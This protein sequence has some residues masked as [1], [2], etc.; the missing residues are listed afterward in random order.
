MTC[1]HAT[2]TQI[3]YSELSGA[4]KRK[5]KGSCISDSAVGCESPWPEH[6]STQKYLDSW[7]SKFRKLCQNKRR[8]RQT[9]DEQYEALAIHRGGKMTWELS[10]KSGLHMEAFQLRNS[11]I[12]N[13]TISTIEG[14]QT[15][16]HVK[17]GKVGVPRG[18]D[19]LR[20]IDYCETTQMA[21]L[22]P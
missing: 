16:Q 14:Q 9:A 19:I 17:L 8:R 6:Q 21:T 1:W 3:F 13:I 7:A 10:T 20:S 12:C 4:I 11:A 5:G 15:W 18:E 2:S 22:P